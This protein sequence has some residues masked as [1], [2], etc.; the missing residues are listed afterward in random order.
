VKAAAAS[1]CLV[2]AILVATT[3]PRQ[4]QAAT[5]PPP[6]VIV[7]PIVVANVAPSYDHIGHVIAIQSVRL[8]PR[9]TAFIDDVAVEQG[10]DVKV[11][12]VLFSLQKTQ[13]Q[14]ALQTAQASLA[15]A[16][17]AEANAELA[18]E[19]AARLTHNGFV[20]QSTLDQALATRNQDRASVLSAQASITQA[21][22]NLTYCTITAPIGGR[23]GAV[24]LTKGNLVTP[25]TGALATINQLDPIRVV[26]SVSDSLIVSA[27]QRSKSTQKQLAEGVQVSLVLPNGKKYDHL[28]KIAFSDNQVDTQ[29]GTISLYADFA[30]PDALL[31][32]GS[33]VS[34][35]T[36]QAK[37]E[38]RPLVPVAAVQT[39]KTGTFVLLIGAGNKVVQQ[40]V[41]LGQQISQDY[42]V[43]KGLSAGDRVVVEGAQKVKSGEVVN[44]TTAPPA[45]APTTV[46]AT[47]VGQ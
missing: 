14:A 18:Y 42:I 37:P 25:T 43:Q 28:G 21:Q 44:P 7:A 36:Q 1:G 17:A 4:V 15:S 47:P 38:E 34:V 31:L 3:T 26:F 39:D 45:Q 33:Y 6:S 19:R 32:P 20:A 8:V 22:L 40:P 46:N 27:K 35:E 9:V 13:Y 30:N 11:G 41:V 2:L 10:S 12:Q 5:A 23:I 29:T 24:T 16:Q